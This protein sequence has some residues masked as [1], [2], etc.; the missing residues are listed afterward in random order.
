LRDSAR[1]AGSG[2]RAARAAAP[3]VLRTGYGSTPAAD[4]AAPLQAGSFGMMAIT[5][6]G[7]GLAPDL[8]PGD[9]VVGTEVVTVRDGRPDPATAVP[10]PAAPL[11]LG[12]LRRGGAGGLP[13][14][15]R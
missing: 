1:A 14:A 3:A 10:I 15:H 7:A 8:H 4:R 9:L 6:T 12:E 13:G 5:G 2:R 11:L